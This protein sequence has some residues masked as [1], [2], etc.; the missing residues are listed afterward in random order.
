M[1]K[2][3]EGLFKKLKNKNASHIDDE[4]LVAF[5]QDGLSA[6]E[7]DLTKAHLR[8]CNDCFVRMASLQKSFQKRESIQVESTPTF[9]VEQAKGLVKPN[10]WKKF[11][12]RIKG[13]F[14][15][16]PG[17]RYVVPATVVVTVLLLVMFYPTAPIKN[18]SMGSKLSIWKT[19]LLKDMGEKPELVKYKGMS[20]EFSGDR[21]FIIF[22]WQ[23][24]S[25]AEY[26]DIYLY[27]NKLPE[28]LTRI[29][30]IDQTRFQVSLEKLQ[31]KKKT[32]Y[33]WEITGRLKDGGSFNARRGFML[34]K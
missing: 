31:L 6:E 8:E 3:T 4:I 12:E 17:W 16:I 10:I 32:K 22:Q 13:W 1:R 9:L 23:E 26:Y 25:G 15:P 34:R 29:E 28:R 5:L 20:V 19:P 21:K 11:Y 30:E 2:A 14:E 24:V 27:K 7:Q 18:Y 33:D